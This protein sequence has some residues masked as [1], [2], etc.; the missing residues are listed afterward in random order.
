MFIILLGLGYFATAIK[1]C[2]VLG[3]MLAVI[4]GLVLGGIGVVPVAIILALIK[5]EWI[6]FTSLII[7]LPIFWLIQFAYGRYALGFK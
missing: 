2:Y 4:I 1:A 6:I 3:G 7:W 5:G